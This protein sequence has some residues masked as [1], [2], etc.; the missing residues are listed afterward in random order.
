MTSRR[1]LAFPPAMGGEPAWVRVQVKT[2]TRWANRFLSGMH[3]SV[4]RDVASC[5]ALLGIRISHLL[6]HF[7]VSSFTKSERMIAIKDLQTDLCDG[8]ML[9]NLLEL[10]SG[11]NPFKLSFQD[12]FTAERIVNVCCIN[13]RK[14]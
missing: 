7:K 13:N 5:N 3:T 14:V 4:L 6:S 10:I 11:H 1:C 2:F 9:I 12:T 8:V